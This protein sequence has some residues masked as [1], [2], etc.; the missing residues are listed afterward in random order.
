[1]MQRTA[2]FGD[3]DVHR[4]ELGRVWDERKHSCVWLM[5]NPS[6]ADA[7]VDDPTIKR[8][9]GFSQAWGYGGLTILNIFAFK[10]TDPDELLAL[11]PGQAIGPD[12]DRT[13]DDWARRGLDFYLGWGVH[14]TLY[15]RGAQVLDRLNHKGTVLRALRTTMAGAPGHPLY[16]PAWVKPEPY[17]RRGQ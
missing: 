2:R 1:M 8:C 14:G 11:G 16:I 6:T 15:G 10:A 4:Y 5:L 9:I 7:N 17:P 13:I 3:G 12:N